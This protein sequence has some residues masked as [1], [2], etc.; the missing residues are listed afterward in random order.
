MIG[1]KVVGISRADE[2]LRLIV[3]GDASESFQ[4]MCVR[5]RE[6]AWVDLGDSIWWQGGRVYWSRKGR[7][8]D[9]PLTKVG[10][11]RRVLTVD[12]LPRRASS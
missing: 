9:V 11:S 6:R 8:S 4:R 10:N 2:G 1:G 12:P 3:A 7:F 5:T